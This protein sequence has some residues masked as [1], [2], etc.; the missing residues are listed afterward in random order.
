MTAFKMTL[1]LGGVTV[2]DEGRTAEPALI[3][4]YN[5]KTAAMRPNIATGPDDNSNVMLCQTAHTISPYLTTTFNQT[6]AEGKFPISWKTHKF[7]DATAACN[8]HPTSL[9][10][11]V[12]KTLEQQVHNTIMDNLT[13]NNLLSE[14]QFGF[15]MEHQPRKL[16]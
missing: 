3:S 1:H 9:L 8:Y 15:C 4:V 11:L 14:K 7:S 2:N 6:L 16:S 13:V 12:S 5:R 10:S